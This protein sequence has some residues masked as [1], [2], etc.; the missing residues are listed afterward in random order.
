[1]VHR[2]RWEKDGLCEEE[3]FCGPQGLDVGGKRQEVL[4]T[5]RL[6]FRV[7]GFENPQSKR[8]HLN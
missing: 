3:M 4:R 2:E 1:M 5:P 7:P 6:D 8:G